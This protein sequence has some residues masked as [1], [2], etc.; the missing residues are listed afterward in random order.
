MF[1]LEDH[2]W[3]YNFANKNMEAHGFTPRTPLS[4]HFQFYE[5]VR[6]QTADNNRILNTPTPEVIGRAQVLARNVLDPIRKKFGIVL[7]NSWFRCETLERHIAEKGYNSWCI[8]NGYAQT[9]L[10]WKAYFARKQHPLGSAAD[11][12]V[13]DPDISNIEL[14]NWIKDNL[15]FD[16]LI[17]ENA[18]NPHDPR[19]GWVH[20]SFDPFGNNRNEA[21][22]LNGQ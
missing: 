9:E 2:K 15:E 16:Q 3:E 20:V 22:L 10:T 14:Y 4:D 17:L 7:V 19:S 13:K 8:K 6:S 21:F 11:I 18:T 12:E 1:R 5:L